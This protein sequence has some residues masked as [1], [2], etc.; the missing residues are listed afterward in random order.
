M[1]ENKQQ[2]RNQAFSQIIFPM[3]C[4]VLVVVASTYFLFINLSAGKMDYRV[5]SDI[6]ILLI[7]LPVILSFV[8]SFIFIA[9]LIFIISIFQPKLDNAL[10][11]VNSIIKSISFW[12]IKGAGL[13]SRPMIHL[14]SFFTQIFSLLKIKQ[15]D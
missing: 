14:E 6:S 13:I 4:I 1:M 10:L 11:K 8:F 2:I 12:T 9:G 5:W 3:I 7:I 15:E